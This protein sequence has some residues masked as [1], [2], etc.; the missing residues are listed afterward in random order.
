MNWRKYKHKIKSLFSIRFYIKKLLELREQPEEAARGLALG[1]F[2]GFLPVNGFQVLIAI[3]I[4]TLARVSKVAAA[5]GT[6]VTNPWTTVPVL[7]IDYYVGCSILKFI[8]IKVAPISLKTISV[9]KLLSTGISLIV[10]TFVGGIFLG[11]IFSILSYFGFKKFIVSF[12]NRK[13]ETVQ[14]A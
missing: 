5:I 11:I 1:V 12:K 10:P 4:A 8:G 14:S 6:H 7:I 13:K 3:T 2:I 9:S